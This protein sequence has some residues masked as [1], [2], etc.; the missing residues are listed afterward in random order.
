[1]SLIQL[2][3]KQRRLFW[4]HLIGDAF[5]AAASGNEPRVPKADMDAAGNWLLSVTNLL[6]ISSF[7]AL[8]FCLSCYYRITLIGRDIA[9]SLS[10]PSKIKG[11][12]DVVEFCNHVQR[13]W[14]DID[15]FDK[16]M[17]PQVTRVLSSC[18]NN[19]ILAFSPLNYFSNLRLS[20]PFLLLLIHQ[21]IREQ[22]EFRK[23]LSSAYI[24]ASQDHPDPYKTLND[25]SRDEA[26]GVWTTAQSHVQILED[27][28][29]QSIDIMLR[30]C[31]AQVGMFKALMPTG[32][33]QTAMLLLREL[34][35]TAQFLAEV[36]TNE[37]GYPDDTPGGYDWTWEKKQEEMN[38]CI[39]ALYQVGWAWADVADVLDKIMVTME[40]L[41][42]TPA[43]LA[44]YKERVASRPPS[45]TPKMTEAARRREQEK[46]DDEAALKAVLSHWPPVSVPELIENAIATGELDLQNDQSVMRLTFFH[47]RLVEEMDSLAGSGES[48][49]SSPSSF[50]SP[51][52]AS[53]SGSSAQGGF[54]QDS[55]QNLRSTNS[56]STNPSTAKVLNDLFPH[57]WD[58]E[59]LSDFNS[60]GRCPDNEQLY[61]VRTWFNNG[62]PEDGERNGQ[63][64]KPTGENSIRGVGHRGM[65]PKTS[66]TDLMTPLDRAENKAGLV[67]PD[68]SIESQTE[69]LSKESSTSKD[70]DEAQDGLQEFFDEWGKDMGLEITSGW[71][72]Y[73]GR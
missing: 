18:P 27:L 8:S 11:A 38:C 24:A 32:T 20:S 52:V 45:Q 53:E 54:G 5:W 15:A 73:R 40:R 46:K 50:A 68:I 69:N 59:F 58:R 19:D 12:V 35:A 49:H 67:V 44:A 34:I 36:P 71:M 21:L 41:T 61:S 9:T 57:T 66:L 4:A 1:M 16:D 10:I 22:L 25:E 64:P 7:N 55:T 26:R 43:Q 23:T 13:I 65:E 14:R 42:P 60:S 39:E 48:H 2:K 51:E 3:M 47:S 28:S 30:S 70:A 33:I 72:D 62:K 31:R 17:N 63:S 56:S 37:Q 29:S 6:P